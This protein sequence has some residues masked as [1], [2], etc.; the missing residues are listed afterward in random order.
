MSPQ[1]SSGSRILIA[2]LSVAVLGLVAALY[3]V[4]RAPEPTAG[5]DPIQPAATGTERQA[6]PPARTGGGFGSAE[7]GARPQLPPTQRRNALGQPLNEDGRPIGPAAD[8]AGRAARPIADGEFPLMPPRLD[9][10]AERA[11]FKAWWTEEFERRVAIYQELEPREEGYPD[12]DEVAT[13]IDELYET[14][15]PRGAGESDEQI[16]ARR[17][18]WRTALRGF[19]RDF[20]APPYTI[21]NRAG[22]PQYGQPTPPPETAATAA[23]PAGPVVP[24]P[25]A[26]MAPPGRGSD[27]PDGTAPITDRG[28]ERGE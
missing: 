26:D 11:A 17:E 3:W 6:M 13:M 7:R 16:L 21:V 18:R 1:S 4:T 5:P 10:S 15:L 9:D 25:P 23:P 14:G 27:D 12:P 22:D 20:G 24:A 19:I 8:I 2:A 28:A